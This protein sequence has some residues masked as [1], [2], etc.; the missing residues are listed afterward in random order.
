MS[1]WRAVVTAVVSVALLLV[2]ALPA[3]SM[4]VGLP[5]GGSEPE[6]SATYNGFVVSAEEFGAGSNATLLVT[7]ELPD[8]LERRHRGSRGTTRGRP[9]A[10]RPRQRDRG[11]PDRRLR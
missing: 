8:G 6:G 9:G 3:L 10:L 1:T 11:R 7:A 4:R 5:D 2:V